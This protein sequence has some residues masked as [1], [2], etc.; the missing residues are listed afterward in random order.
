MIKKM[1][2]QQIRRHKGI[3]FTGVTTVFVCHDGRGKMLLA[4]RSQN[5]R[6]EKGR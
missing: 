5:A 4:K 3:S 2:P 1:T 6:D